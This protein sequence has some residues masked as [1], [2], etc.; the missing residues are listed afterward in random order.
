MRKWFLLALIPFLMAA[1]VGQKE[2]PDPVPDPD[3]D[4]ETPIDPDPEPD[5]EPEGGDFFRRVLALDFTGSWCQYCP[6][7]DRALEEAR[8]ARPDRFVSIAVHAY[9]D[10]SAKEATALISQFKVSSYPTMVFDWDVSTRFNETETSLMLQYLDG[11]LE[12]ETAACGLAVTAKVTEAVLQVSVS[13]KAASAGTY[14]LVA[15]LVEDGIVS[16]QTGYGAGFV[17]NAVLRGFL[18]PGVTGVTTDP[19]AEGLE[20]ATEFTAAA[21]ATP[22]HY[23]IVVFA[24]GDGK[25]R[26][27]V[28]CGLNETIDF[29][30]EKSN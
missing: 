29:S 17:N 25:V 18:A 11:V 14:A 8:Q 7:M 22:D 5:P 28:S 19:L 4:P 6:N 2:D 15:A 27:V 23:R 21:P 12:R 3:P 30:Y 24:M 16:V 26:N 9:D 10:M 20:F 13:L 1:C